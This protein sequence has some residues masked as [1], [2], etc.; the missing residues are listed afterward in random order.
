[1]LVV[2]TRPNDTMASAAP[3]P[4]ASLTDTC[5]VVTGR[6]AVRLTCLSKSRSAT[7][8]TQQPAL[9]M[10]MV[11]STNT[12]SR[13]QPGKPSAAIH[14]ALSV[15]HR[16]TNQPAGRS[17][18]MRSRYRPKRLRGETADMAGNGWNNKEG[19]PR[20][21]ARAGRTECSS[22]AVARASCPG[23]RPNPVKCAFPPYTTHR[24]A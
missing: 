20:P 23:A 3:R 6:C 1:M 21:H 13:C 11:P 8:F 19:L 14:S 15:G 22:N 7:S 24:T 2:S 17:Q 18:R 10:R 12:M 9:R 16:H 4:R 5:P